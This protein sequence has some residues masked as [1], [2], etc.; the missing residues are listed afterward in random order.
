MRY[1]LSFVFIFYVVAALSQDVAFKAESNADEVI[2]G[3]PFKV[4]FILEN[5]DIRNI[6][7]PNFESDGFSVI[8]GPVNESRY[9]NINGKASYSEAYIFIISPKKTGKLSLGSAKVVT[10]RGKAITTKPLIISVVSG[11]S[12][13][14][15]G[16]NTHNLP[17]AL[18]GKV[19]FRMEPSTQKAVPGQEIRLDLK[20]Y[21]QVDLAGIELRKEPNSDFVELNPLSYFDREIRMDVFNGKQFASK[22]IY[23]FSFFAGKTGEIEIKPAAVDIFLGRSS[24]AN[25]F[26]RPQSYPLLSNPVKI[27]VQDFTKSPQNFS[28]AVG[29]YQMDVNVEK[30]NI[31]SDD[32]LKVTVTVM[33][34]GD[35]KKLI[36]IP[37]LFEGEEMPF[38]IYPPKIR[39]QSKESKEGL[40]GIKEFVYTLE[41]LKIGDFKMR[42]TFIYY[43]VKKKKFTTVDTTINIKVIQGKKVLTSKSEVEKSEKAELAKSVVFTEPLTKAHWSKSSKPFFGSFMFWV[44][45]FLPLIIFSVLASSKLFL[46]KRYQMIIEKRERTKA[47]RELNELLKAAEEF[48]KQEDAPGF[49]KSISEAFKGYL[50][51]KL[52]LTNSELTKEKMS[53]MLNNKIDERHI[54]AMMR[55]LN[56][57]ELSVFAGQDNQDAMQK[58]F[59]DSCDLFEIFS[60][61]FS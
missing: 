60:K 45:T 47:E 14:V 50:G 32:L 29:N 2:V 27:E 52:L 55:I 1:L 33:G 57:C 58:V 51:S 16:E 54:R 13:N 53:D 10:S 15:V 26:A 23:S 30:S 22:I 24:A 34:Y 36:K 59:D 49:Y 7:F 42:P 28:G 31:S 3:N 40:S 18:A 19:F 37:F 11:S 41:P 38:D 5:A 39:D 35:I 4:S 12:G 25:P 21:T 8:Q 61:T 44:L 20:V 9:V 56:I 48:L 43:D 46:K 17:A 6:S